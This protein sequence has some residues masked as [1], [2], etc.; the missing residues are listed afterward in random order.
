MLTASI[1]WVYTII[2]EVFMKTV[3][4][5]K[6]KNRALLL[7]DLRRD[8]W[9]YVFLI[10][11]GIVGSR[12]VGLDQFNRLFRTPDFFKIVKNTLLLNVY[13]LVF[14]FPVPIILAILLNEVRSAL[15]KRV[16]QS[17]LYL[18]HFISW[19][20]LAGIQIFWFSR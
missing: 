14:G 17:I 18:P 4:I 15:F 10:G 13:A 16:N 3:D 6:T 5:V 8:R 1:T 7:R 2:T 20:V 12:W 11:L 9:L 19:V